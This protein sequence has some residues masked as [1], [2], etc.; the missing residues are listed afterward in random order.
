[1]SGVFLNYSP[2]YILRQDVSLEPELANLT[3]LPSQL[4]LVIPCLHLPSPENTGGPPFPLTF[5]WCWESELKSSLCPN[6]LF[7]LWEICFS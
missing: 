4:A 3:R 1:M 6:Y 7:T 5:M 2:S